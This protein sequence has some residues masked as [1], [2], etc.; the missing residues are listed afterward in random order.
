[1]H[2]F[3]LS[4]ATNWHTDW[5]RATARGLETTDLTNKHIH[6]YTHFNVFDNKVDFD[7]DLKTSCH[8]IRTAKANNFTAKE[9]TS[10]NEPKEKW[11][12]FVQKQLKIII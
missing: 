7:F 9:M 4:Y 11:V 10:K 5:C 6:I 1:M 12:Q 3:I 8:G 2:S